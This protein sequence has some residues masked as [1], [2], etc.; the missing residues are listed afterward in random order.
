M[1]V[2]DVIMPVTVGV[3]V[4][5]VV[6]IV[7][8]DENTGGVGPNGVAEFARASSGASGIAESMFPS[9]APRTGII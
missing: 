3:L 5:T 6:V 4:L 9:N 2:G 8:F 7:V 1:D